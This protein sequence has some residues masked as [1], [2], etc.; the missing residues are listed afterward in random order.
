MHTHLKGKDTIFLLNPY[1]GQAKME[2]DMY[3]CI[4]APIQREQKAKNEK[5]PF[6]LSTKG[7]YKRYHVMPNGL[8]THQQHIGQLIRQT[9]SHNR[10]PVCEADSHSWDTYDSIP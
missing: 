8:Y 7:T 10:N 6:C 5:S 2:S 4:Q 3:P 9:T 1:K